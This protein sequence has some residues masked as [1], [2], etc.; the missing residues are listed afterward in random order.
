V[1]LLPSY[2]KEVTPTEG[3]AL[4]AIKHDGVNRQ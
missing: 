4:K 3:T 2:K 1:V